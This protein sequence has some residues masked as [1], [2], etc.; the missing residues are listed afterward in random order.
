MDEI[1]FAEP[2]QWGRLIRSTH[3]GRT[4]PLRA[5]FGGGH[6]VFTFVIWAEG[7]A[8][9]TVSNIQRAGPAS[10]RGNEL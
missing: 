8:G 3:Q 2:G 4:E 5:R 6:K 9:T 10:S 1:D 7:G